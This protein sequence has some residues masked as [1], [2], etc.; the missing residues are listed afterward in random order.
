MGVPVVTD[1]GVDGYPEIGF[2]GVPLVEGALGV[3]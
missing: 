2:G 1:E 3:G